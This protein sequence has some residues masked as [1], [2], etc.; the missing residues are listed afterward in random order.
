MMNSLW[1]LV[2]GDTITKFSFR[3][4]EGGRKLD[5]I[6][7]A[8]LFGEHQVQLGTD[9][10]AISPNGYKQPIPTNSNDYW[11]DDGG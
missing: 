3:P 7:L 9:W 5:V 8:S 10:L 11:P 4:I 1:F 6:T 2:E